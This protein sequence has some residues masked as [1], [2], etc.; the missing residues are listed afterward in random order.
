MGLEFIYLLNSL[1][2]ML[3]AEFIQDFENCNRFIE[4]LLSNNIKIIRVTNTQLIEH[5]TKM[6]PEIEIR[7]STSQEYTSIRQYRNL[8]TIFPNITEIVP[9]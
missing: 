9:S 5:I 4:L 7:T 8:F 3:P 1:R 2:T 6:Y